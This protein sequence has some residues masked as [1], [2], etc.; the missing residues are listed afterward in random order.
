MQDAK[1]QPPPPGSFQHFQALIDGDVG[2]PALGAFVRDRLR[3]APDPG[4]PRPMALRVAT[5][6]SAYLDLCLGEACHVA[7][8]PHE[9]RDDQILDLASDCDLLLVETS[10]AYA[11]RGWG[12]DI[13]RRA[14]AGG[15]RIARLLEDCRRRGLPT[16]LWI[17][18]DRTGLDAFAHLHGRFDRSFAADPAVAGALGRGEVEILPPAVAPTL[19]NPLQPGHDGLAYQSREFGVCTDAYFE[20]T[21]P[22]SP[23]PDLLEPALDHLLWIF[24]TRFLMRNN[25]ARLPKDYR[26]RF[27]GCLEEVDRAAILRNAHVYVS[28]ARHAGGAGGAG[29][30]GV[31]RTRNAMEAMAAKAAVVT[32][33]PPVLEAVRPFAEAVE[34]PEA[35]RAALEAL[36]FQP[37][38]RR[39]VTHMAY[40][41]VLSHH[42]YAHRLRR[43]AAALDVPAWRIGGGAGAAGGGVD[44]SATSVTAI[45]PTMRPELLPF[46][47]AG[48]RRSTHPD[49]DLLIVLHSDEYGPR[50]VAPMLRE[51]DRARVIRVPESQAVGAAINAG[52]DEAQ[53]E[54]WAKIDDDDYY[55]PRFFSDMMLNRAFGDF[56][57][58]GKSQWMIYFEAL[59]AV[60][61][62]KKDWAAHSTN[63][64][65]AGGTFVVRRSDDEALRFDDRVRGFTDIDMLGRAVDAGGYRIVSGDPFGFL[66]VRRRDRRTHAWTADQDQIRRSERICDGIDLTRISV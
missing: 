56:D 47:L 37:H 17:T 51:D 36:T 20:M 18:E 31:A 24:E 25:N 13:R 66:Q 44:P 21:A 45:M 58:G 34:T 10:W 52:I 2:N 42:T 46:A 49:L 7:A 48:H 22:G 29:S 14:D 19:H 64:A 15:R 59:D 11:S 63:T 53:G 3:P 43:I 40:R 5:I 62:H 8:L 61:A 32:N 54:Y 33:A 50:D 39:M 16:A 55:G 30:G 35:M 38:Y 57:I 26:R 23:L 60:F 6:A 4:R 41:E 9:A 28:G 12:P 1:I 65:L 27:L